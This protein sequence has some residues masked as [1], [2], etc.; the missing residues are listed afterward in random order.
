MK[1]PTCLVT[2]FVLVFSCG[3]AYATDAANFVSQS[4]PT[5]MYVGDTASVSVT[6]KNPPPSS[7]CEKHCSLNCCEDCIECLQCYCV[8]ITVTPSAWTYPNYKLGSQNPPDNAIWGTGRVLLNSGETV[9]SGAQKTFNF[10]IRAPSTPGAYNFQWR[11]LQEGVNWFGDLTPNVVIN[12]IARPATTTRPTTTTTGPPYN[13]AAYVSQSVPSP[14]CTGKSYSVSVTMRNTGTTTWTAAGNYRLG[15]QNPQDNTIWGTGRVFLSGSD[16]IGP[17]ASKTFAFT[18]TAPSTPGTYN[19]QWRMVQ[20]G[21]EWF[22]GYT[23]NVAVT[24]NLCT[25]TTTTRPSTT[26]TTRP[27]TTTTTRPSTTTT[28]TTTTTAPTASVVFRYRAT[29]DHKVAACTIWADVFGPWQKY[30]TDTEIENG[31]VNEFVMDGIPPGTYKWSVS[32]IDDV[33]QGS[34]LKNAPN[35]YWTFTVS[36]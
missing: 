5:T 31:A 24:V 2:L 11:M 21:V 10:Q 8:Y 28:T 19:F 35:G 26:T 14:M 15:S 30:K 16:S 4:V 22:G 18:V 33:P 7:V 29:D 23:P 12:V 34:V 17:G 9:A 3:S 20:D 1:N 13:D 27:S 36:A 32:C 6:M 25:T